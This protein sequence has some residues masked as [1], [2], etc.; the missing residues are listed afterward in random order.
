MRWSDIGES[1]CSIARAL[2][3]VGDRWTLLILREAFFGVRRFEDFQ[4]L[5]QASPRLVADRLGKLVAEGVMEKQAY[6][7]RPVRHE[8]RL[9]AKGRE[10]HP[11]M[12]TLSLW[13]QRWMGAP[14]GPP[15]TLVHRGC[16]RPTRPVLCCS[17]CGEPVGAR[18]IQVEF[19]QA[20]AAERA[21]LAEP[22]RT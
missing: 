12:V 15:V 13:G 8:Y 5:T 2:A 21:R 4:R 6:Q 18:D 19:G 22:D 16:G 10:L 11:V 7:E 20:Y 3:I 1:T 14:D 17:E 9:T